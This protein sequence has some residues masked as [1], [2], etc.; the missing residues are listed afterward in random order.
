[1][2]TGIAVLCVCLLPFYFWLKFPLVF[3]MCFWSKKLYQANNKP[4]EVV[5]KRNNE[6]I[7]NDG[8]ADEAVLL[9]TSMVFPWLTILNFKL[10]NLRP[11][12]IIIFPDNLDKEVFRQLRVRLKV[13]SN[14]LFN[15]KS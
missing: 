12:S 6:W 7:I 5:W 2:V 15:S 14:K 13:T 1:M 10:K 9:S 4:E 8:K 3:I 11:K